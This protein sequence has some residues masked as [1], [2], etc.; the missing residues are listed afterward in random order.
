ME[1]GK[2]ELA[3]VRES[4]QVKLRKVSTLGEINPYDLPWPQA[5]RL[6]GIDFGT[7]RIG[8]SLCDPSRTW[9]GPLETFE[10]KATAIEV[11]HF[12]KLTRENQIAGWVLGLPLH[13]DGRDSAK[14]REVRQFAK[15]LITTTDRPVRFIDERYTTALA[16][17]MLRDLDL[18]HKQRK[19]QLD[20]IA[21]HIILDA[22]LQS[23]KHPSFI[24][25]TLENIDDAQISLDDALDGS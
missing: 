9:T 13:C 14:A 6:A 23:S 5:G 4:N 2:L 25:I 11:K 12:Q 15:W 3:E 16:T 1:L 8:V 7:V 24:P 21:A 20:K 19:K 10:R 18:T 22:Y 17:R